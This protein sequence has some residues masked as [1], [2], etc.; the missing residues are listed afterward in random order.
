MLPTESGSAG[1]RF[2]LLQDVNVY[3][4]RHESQQISLRPFAEHG[5]LRVA[6]QVNQSGR[7][8]SDGLVVGGDGR[9]AALAVRFQP[10]AH[11]TLLCHADSGSTGQVKSGRCRAQARKM[12]VFLTFSGRFQET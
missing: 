10:D 3:L 12:P 5:R 1:E 8:A 6:L 11:P 2:A 9:V 4:V 7:Q